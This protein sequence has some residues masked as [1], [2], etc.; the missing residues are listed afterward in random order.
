MV[1]SI[2]DEMKQQVA[3]FEA[4][5]Q[6]LEA[7]RI[8]SRTNFDVE[9]MLEI[10]TCPGIENYSLY[11]SGRRPGER[12]ACLIDYFPE[13]FLIV[14]DE[15]HASVPQLHGMYKGDRS[16]K[17]TLIEHGFRLPSALDNRPL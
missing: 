14:A 4:A 8:E 11:T 10:G 5:G 12:P 9:M 15:S 17:E 3:A 13:D 2:R 16:R 6:L 7:Q 1:P